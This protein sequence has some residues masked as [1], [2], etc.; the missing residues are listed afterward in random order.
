MQI[1]KVTVIH[2]H[3]DTNMLSNYRP[4]SILPLFSKPLE[5]II[6][7]RV[8]TFFT[9]HSCI[10]NSQFGFRQKRSTETALLTIKEELI[11]N[12][13]KRLYTLGIF[14]DFSKA[15][16]LVIHDLLLH[17]LR[18]YGIRGL[19][20]RLFET[21]LQQRRQYVEI[22]GKRSNIRNLNTGVPQGSILGP[23]LFNIYINDIVNI[24]PNIKFIIYAD[25]ASLFLAGDKPIQLCTLANISLSA[26]HSWSV[27][28]GMVINA[29]KTK[30][31]QSQK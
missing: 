23:L 14:V 22:G 19:A 1:A 5:R 16:D 2:K 18:H 27:N 31:V 6:S 11:A 24:A 28:N 15:F 21:Y 20:I 9:K 25:D 13:E 17:K 8:T 29:A 3:G 26:L 7:T 4:I 12:I 30:A 10:T